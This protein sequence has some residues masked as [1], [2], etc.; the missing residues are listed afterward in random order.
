MAKNYNW[1]WASLNIIGIILTVVGMFGV[2]GIL[3]FEGS[4]A[5]FILGTLMILVSIVIV[6]YNAFKLGMFKEPDKENKDILTSKSV[7][8]EDE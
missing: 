4:M 6:F 7:D 2:I 8:K 3:S 5:V 1:L